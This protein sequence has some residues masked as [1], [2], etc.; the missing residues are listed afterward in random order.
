MK[1]KATVLCE[2]C[3]YSNLGALAEHGWSIFLETDQGNFLFDTGQ[4]LAL[5]NNARVF[6]K[7]LASVR[8]ILLSHHHIDH[9]GGLRSALSVTQNVNVYAHPDL[10]KESYLTRGPKTKYIGIPF[11][12]IEL[13]SQ[14]ANFVFNTEFKE[15]APG[16]YLTGEVP[17]KTDFEIGDLD[18]VIKSGD[19][20]IKD[21]MRDDQSLI[22]KTEKGLFVIL[23]CSHAGIINI[24]DYAREM[25]GETRIH[26]VIGGTHL[27]PVSPEQREKSITALKAFDI[28]RLGVSHCTGLPALLRLAQEF[29]ERFFFCNVGTVV[30]A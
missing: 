23:G 27:G 25:T 11:S 3:V 7:D 9:T 20:F 30:E 17:R 28:E 1:I 22:I 15:I 29:K 12:R 19:D 26:A 4:G 5:L 13:E 24:L 2:N 18:Q 14:G 16:M 10:F 8:G 6:K 21:P